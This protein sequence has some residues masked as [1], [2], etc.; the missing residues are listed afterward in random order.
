MPVSKAQMRATAKYKKENYEQLRVEVK[1]GKKSI[2]Q[3]HASERN[4]SLNG[5]VN[6]AIDSQV[7]R[8][9]EAVEPTANANAVAV[10]IAKQETQ[11]NTA[12]RSESRKP[13]QERIETWLKLS[14]SG[15]GGGSIAK[16][17]EGGGWGQ[18]TIKKY[19]RL[20]RQAAR[21]E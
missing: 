10:D 8:D 19:L 20:A 17:P 4:E 5:F 1:K 21:G 9:R 7:E 3:A 12:N 18:T 13:S 2:I 14:E 11:H 16:M 6:R 15:I